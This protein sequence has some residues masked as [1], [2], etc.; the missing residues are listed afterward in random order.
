MSDEW[1]IAV[2]RDPDDIDFFETLHHA[3]SSL[4]HSDAAE[5]FTL[6]LGYLRGNR[7]PEDAKPAILTSLYTVLKV[8]PC[9]KIF[10]DGWFGSGLPF[11]QTKLS[12][13][14]LNILLLL[15]RKSPKVFDDSMCRS[16]Q[17]FI[18]TD[19]KK[20][21][22]LI[23]K[24]AENFNPELHG[25]FLIDLLFPEPNLLAESD[26]IRYSQVLGYLA[27]YSTFAEARG[28]IS[29]TELVKLLERDDTETLIAV[30]N[31]LY[32][33]MSRVPGQRVPF[34]RL[35]QHLSVSVLQSSVLNLLLVV[36]FVGGQG[37]F[38]GVRG[39]VL[40]RQLIRLATEDGDERATLI[41]MRITRSHPKFAR[42]LLSE[43][44]WMDKLLPTIS[45]T[46]KLFLIVFSDE[47][48]RGEIAGDPD[49]VT[50]LNNLIH[51]GQKYCWIA[52]EILKRLPVL[53]ERLLTALD[54]SQFIVNFFLLE[55]DEKSKE[56][57]I[58]A[59]EFLVTVG[60][61]HYSK[62]LADACR[63]LLRK[64]I[65]QEPKVFDE[66]AHAAIELATEPRYAKL[67][68]ELEFVE[69]FRKLR[70]KPATKVVAATF[71][72]AMHADFVADE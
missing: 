60:K 42:A 19:P 38:H 48:L 29:C 63:K 8:G 30:Y 27:T 25:W 55:Q 4:P 34:D 6:V 71:L 41:L 10:V 47:T 20:V 65:F 5:Y 2:I 62:D 53:P 1:S 24:C 23:A 66:A 28:Q 9:R 51:S 37:F 58:E 64:C 39:P 40:F 33:T 12:E 57:K 13:R 43:A 17:R 67:F 22:L 68:R 49:L 26:P 61:Q 45:Y 31:A 72:K 70:K 3:G 44:A 21:L 11:S 18:K 7:V 59:L 52:L 54:T 46:L 35:K 32:A 56:A 36:P 15:V 69:H 14:V 16:L 50:F